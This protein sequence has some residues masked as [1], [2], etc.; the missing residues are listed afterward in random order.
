M[1]PNLATIGET[2]ERRRPGL[3]SAEYILESIV[4]PG[5][6]RAST[7]T[8][9]MPQ[10][11]AMLLDVDDIRNL[12]AFLSSQRAAPNYHEIAELDVQAVET[13]RT[14]DRVVSLGR[15]EAGKEIFRTKGKCIGC[16]PLDGSPG[17]DLLAPSILTAG[18][19]ST[20]YLQQSLTDPNR[21]ITPAY[22]TANVVLKDGRTFIGRLLKRSA[23]RV[24]LLTKSESGEIRPLNI[25][26]SDLETA[27]D[28]QPLLVVSK[29][30]SMPPLGKSLTQDE[31]DLLVAF[32]ISM[33]RYDR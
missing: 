17:F 8:G 26:R 12:V 27:D 33:E 25:A 6:F 9:V 10:N 13:K 14:D 22:E 31:I 2:A 11:V 21:T 28:G 29:V 32:L 20:A 5:A 4:D 30:S 19:H 7:A 3:T 24:T 23:D 1:G 16:H 18:H 15:I